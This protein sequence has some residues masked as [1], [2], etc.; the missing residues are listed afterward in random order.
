MLL[1]TGL[2]H[3]IGLLSAMLG[4]HSLSIKLVQFLQRSVG[5]FIAITG[6]YLIMA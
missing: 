4:I 6:L 3:G 1:V 2:L 5:G